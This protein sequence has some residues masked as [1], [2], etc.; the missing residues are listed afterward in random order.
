[1]ADRQPFVLLVDDDLGTL[2][3]LQDELQEGGVNVDPATTREEATRK[4]RQR[5]PDLVLLNVFAER[6]SIRFLAELQSSA[7]TS[8]VPVLLLANVG[9]EALIEEA[10]AAGAAGYVLKTREAPGDILRRVRS[11]LARRA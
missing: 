8:Q 7:R 6:E 11:L 2:A 9:D 5:I 3:T 10:L 4:V 1:M